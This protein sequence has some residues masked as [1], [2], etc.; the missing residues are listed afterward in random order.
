MFE[1]YSIKKCDKI[2]ID[3]VVDLSD[4][5]KCLNPEC[6]AEFS[7]KGLNSGIVSKHFARK[8]TAPHKNN[9]LVH[10]IY[11]NHYTSHY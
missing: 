3:D 9:A 7:V 1:A 4:T 5:F 8:K 6:K 10:S 11:R 2:S